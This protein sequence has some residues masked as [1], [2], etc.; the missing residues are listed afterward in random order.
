[1]WRTRLTAL[2]EDAKALK[3]AAA[4]DAAA[5]ATL[6]LTQRHCRMAIP[7]YLG[8]LSAEQAYQQAEINLIQAQA[9]RYADTA[10]LFQALG[11]G[12]WHRTDLNGDQEW[13]SAQ[14]RRLAVMAAA[15]V[16]CGCSPKSGCA[17]RAARQERNLDAGTAAENSP[18]HRG[19]RKIPQDHRYHRRGGFRQRP[20]HQRAGAF[21]RTGVA[22]ACFS[23]R[24]SKKGRSARGGDFAGFC[25]RGQHLSQ[26]AGHR[27]ECH[28]N[29][30]IWTRI[31]CRI[32]AISQREEP[33]R[34]R[35]MPP[36]PRPTAMRRCSP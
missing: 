19:R 34:P 33:N 10:A 27:P 16:D 35:P 21:L 32:R 24:R 17:K 1:M 18:L 3:A 20:G 36:A 7:A 30:P 9:S 4:A 28:A 23:G 5:K 25:H 15:L 8:L 13:I 22:P 14:N 2:Q 11:G 26:G 31:C 12:W 6:D 29:S